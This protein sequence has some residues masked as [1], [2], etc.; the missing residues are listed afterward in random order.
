[1]LLDSLQDEVGL[2]GPIRSP[3]LVQQLRDDL[4]G[5]TEI[6]DPNLREVED[7]QAIAA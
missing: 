6:D 3:V 7:R 1:M 4:I 2:V 5:A